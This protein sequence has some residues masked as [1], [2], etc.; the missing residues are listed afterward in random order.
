MSEQNS[1]EKAMRISRMERLTPNRNLMTGIVFLVGIVLGMI[2]MLIADTFFS[3]EKI[4][5]KAL[6]GSMYNFNN[7]NTSNL[8]VNTDAVKAKITAGYLEENFLQAVVD[9]ES[10]EAINMK[11]EFNPADFSVSMLKPIDYNQGSSI[12]GG[13]GFVN[14]TNNGTNKYMFLL[15]G[16][17][18]LRDNLDIKIFSEGRIIYGNTLIVSN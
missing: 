6:K 2:I 5:D 8:D 4:S 13:S 14:I 11:F 9:V 10:G 15:K 18:R 17:N 7:A 12:A 3:D 16:H 1:H